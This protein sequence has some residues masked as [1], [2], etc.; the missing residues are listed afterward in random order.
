MPNVIRILTFKLGADG[1][2][3]KVDWQPAVRFEPPVQ[4]ASRETIREGFALFQETC[5]GCHGLNAVSGMLIPDLRG[6]PSLHETAAWDAIVRAGALR[7]RGM[8]GFGEHLDAQ[9]SAAIRAYVV[10]QAWRALRL[11]QSGP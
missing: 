7:E 4:T 2:L 5:M 9:Q 6:S 11:E 3:P 8:A 1:S 10:D